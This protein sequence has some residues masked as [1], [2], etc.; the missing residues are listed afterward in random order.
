MRTGFPVGRETG[1][2]DERCLS[3]TNPAKVLAGLHI[4]VVEDEV[5][6]AMML[7]DMLQDL[8]CNVELASRIEEAW[9]SLRKRTPD[10]VLLDMNVHGQK[11]VAIAEDLARISV[12]FLLVTGYG[13][14][15]GDPPVIKSAPR[16]QKPFD[17]EDLERRMV[18]VFS[19]RDH[20]EA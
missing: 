6:V 14:G 13:A 16:L 7:E 3:V 9:A 18:E 12:P 19:T 1:R 20:S 11:T 15:H 4:L 10:G 8:G 17:E 2:A 5:M